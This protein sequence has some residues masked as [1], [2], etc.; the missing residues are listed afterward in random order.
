MSSLEN[1]LDMSSL[2]NYLDMSSLENYLDMSSG[3]FTQGHQTMYASTSLLEV[4][5]FTCYSH[6]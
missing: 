4:C 3:P 2:E 6:T 5:V 1:Y